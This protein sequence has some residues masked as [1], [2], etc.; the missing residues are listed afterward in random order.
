[1]D[2]VQAIATAQRI[3]PDRFHKEHFGAE[4][5]VNGEPFQVVAELSGQVVEVGAQETIL[6]ALQRSGIQV[7]TACRNGVCGT[8]LTEVIEGRPDHRDMVLTDEEKA[9]NDRIAVCCSR[10]KSKVLRLLI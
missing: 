2:H 10:S 1:M 4:I 8:C 3:G 9:S 6:A 5:D 7:E